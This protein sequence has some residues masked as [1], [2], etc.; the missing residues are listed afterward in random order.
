MKEIEPISH[1]SSIEL[2]RSLEMESTYS[3]H[4]LMFLL[5]EFME[6]VVVEVV[7]L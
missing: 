7:A 4:L 6:L 1:L 2:A 5:M 3:H